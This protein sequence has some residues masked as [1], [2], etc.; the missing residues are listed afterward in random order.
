M[1]T[2][3]GVVTPAT[4]EPRLRR[5]CL[6]AVGAMAA[7][8]ACSNADETGTGSG[9]AIRDRLYYATVALGRRRRRDVAAAR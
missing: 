2:H 6:L 5:I 3:D 1:T 8:V 7:A 9:I 4:P